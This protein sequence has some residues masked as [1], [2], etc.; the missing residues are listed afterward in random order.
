[1]GISDIS[2]GFGL[3]LQNATLLRRLETLA[4]LLNPSSAVE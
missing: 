2:L 4:K 3:L 1:M